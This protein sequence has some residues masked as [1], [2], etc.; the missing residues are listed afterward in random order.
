M[1]TGTEWFALVMDVPLVRYLGARPVDPVDPTAGVELEVTDTAL[2]AAGVVHGGAI[3]TI[4]DLAAYLSVLPVLERE[5]QAV[6][7]SFAA[8]YVSSTG[9][10]ERVIATGTLVRRTRHLAFTT[11]SAMV[12]GR[13][14][15]VASVTKSLVRP[16]QEA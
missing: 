6:T 4:L 2:N 11:S 14:V 12:S 1:P 7:H 8:S 9:R 3:A 13:I 16:R 10:G 15:A 5:E